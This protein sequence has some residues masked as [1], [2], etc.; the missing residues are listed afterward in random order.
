LLDAHCAAELQPGQSGGHGALHRRQAFAALAAAIAQRGA[1]AFGALARQ[2][3]MLPDAATFGRL[4]LSFH[5]FY[6]ILRARNSAPPMSSE[7]PENRNAGAYQRTSGCQ[8]RR[9]CGNVPIWRTER[10]VY[11]AR[12]LAIQPS[13]LFPNLPT[14]LQ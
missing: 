10:G 7:K 8:G 12:P 5:K 14:I 4:I 3:T 6:S 2:E 9:T 11:A 13:G 1:P